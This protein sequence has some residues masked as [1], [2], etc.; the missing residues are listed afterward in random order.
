MSKTNA[1]Q[2]FKKM[3]Q[4]LYSH[5]AHDPKYYIKHVAKIDPPW[6]QDCPIC[7]YYDGECKDECLKLYDEGNGTMCDDQES[8]MCKWQNTNLGDPDFRTW[9]AGKVVKIAS[10]SESN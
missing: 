1:I 10:N 5:P 3:W 6:Q 2:E 4:W 7:D 8:P 9:Y